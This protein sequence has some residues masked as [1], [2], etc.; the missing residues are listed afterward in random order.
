MKYLKADVSCK[1]KIT[2]PVPETGAGKG[3]N[4]TAD[5]CLKETVKKQRS[6]ARGWEEVQAKHISS[7]VPQLEALQMGRAEDTPWSRSCL[8]G[9]GVRRCLQAL[10]SPP[11]TS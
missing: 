4:L 6:L 7:F 5:G 2:F 9:Q 3:S 11:C 8:P 1:G 10:L